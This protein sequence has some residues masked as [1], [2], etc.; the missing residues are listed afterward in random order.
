MAPLKSRR[1]TCPDG[2]PQV[3]ELS[4]RADFLRSEREKLIKVLQAEQHQAASMKQT[5]EALQAQVGLR[6]AEGQ[7]KGERGAEA[8]ALRIC[9]AGPLARRLFF[10][11][12]QVHPVSSP[13]VGTAGPRR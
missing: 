9:A 13:L 4:S 12:S 8:G 5:V 6:G 7:R 10:L 1:L 11:P 2:A 3:K